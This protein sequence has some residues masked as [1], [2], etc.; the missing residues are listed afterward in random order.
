MKIGIIGGGIGG[1]ATANALLHQGLDFE[2]F[3]QASEL[4][5]IGAGVGLS[6]APIAILEKLGLSDKLFSAGA[7]INGACMMDKNFRKVRQINLKSRTVCIHRAKLIAILGKPIPQGKVHLS[8]KARRVEFLNND[9]IGDEVRVYFEDGTTA[10]FDLLIVADGI[11]SVIRKQV[12]P[13]IDVRYANH[14][15]WRG[16]TT[17]KLPADIADKFVE[18]WDKGRRFLC[19]SLDSERTFW[20]ALDRGLPGGKDNPETIISELLDKFSDFDDLALDFIKNTENVLRNDLADLGGKS[21]PW[22]KNSIVFVG[23]SIHATTPNM[24]QGACQAIEDAWCLAECLAQGIGEAGVSSGQD[25][26]VPKSGEFE[27]NEAKTVASDKKSVVNNSDTSLNVA[28]T[29]ASDKKSVVQNAVSG[30]KESVHNVASGNYVGAQTADI[31]KIFA[32]Y[33]SRRE[34]KAMQIVRVSWGFGKLAHAKS[35]IVNALSRVLWS[36]MPDFV[37]RKQEAELNRIT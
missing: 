3:E 20:L 19:I 22:F 7:P 33:Q 25:T 31:S 28:I 14:V 34:G 2:L 27:I 8:K 37:L 36:L 12:F 1:L 30:K 29:V 32:A 35:P 24:A 6:E 10:V 16:I 13:E 21:R 26:E 15:I 9:S 11:N 5:E 17:K 4:T 23:D 18:I